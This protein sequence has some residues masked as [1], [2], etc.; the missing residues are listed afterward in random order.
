MALLLVL[1][2]TTVAGQDPAPAPQP[3]VLAPV[4]VNLPQYPSY[5]GVAAEI[6]R[7]LYG[8]PPSLEQ[9]NIQPHND[10]TISVR[11][12]TYELDD[13]DSVTVDG[14]RLQVLGDAVSVNGMLHYPA[15]PRH[16]RA[17]NPTGSRCRRTLARACTRSS[18]APCSPWPCRLP[19]VSTRV[20]VTVRGHLCTATPRHLPCWGL[21]CC[22]ACTH[23][24]CWCCGLC[25][26]RISAAELRRMFHNDTDKEPLTA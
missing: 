14:Q 22:L 5:I 2:V 4:G 12:E 15:P 8:Q 25:D 9:L 23:R 18:W 16:R 26:G 11:G 3:P 21:L 6:R 10:S 13:T 24:S 19:P 20:G 1:L 17:A 7:A